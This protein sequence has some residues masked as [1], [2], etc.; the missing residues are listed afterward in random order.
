MRRRCEKALLVCRTIKAWRHSDDAD[1]VID[2]ILISV[3]GIEG[4]T[5]GVK[6]DLMPCIQALRF[7]AAFGVFAH[8][9]IARGAFNHVAPDDILE[10]SRVLA[11]G[12]IVF[13]C[14]PAS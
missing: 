14:R 3:G 9:L 8:H 11:A 4:S 5:V 2:V 6:S 13:S 7:L 1:N 10:P 12:V